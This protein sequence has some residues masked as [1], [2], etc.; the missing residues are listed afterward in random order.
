MQVYKVRVHV[1][2]Y[3]KLIILSTKIKKYESIR[4]V[5]SK[6]IYSMCSVAITVQYREL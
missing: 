3:S 5:P 4:T 6:N 2:V 1:Y